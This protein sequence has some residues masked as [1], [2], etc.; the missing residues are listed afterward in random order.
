MIN[1]FCA[2]ASQQSLTDGT[3]ESEQMKE[4]KDLSRKFSQLY[5]SSENSLK[6]IDEM[7]PVSEKLEDSLLCLKVLHKEVEDCLK[8]KDSVTADLDVIKEELEKLKVGFLII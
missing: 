7:I 3:E 1:D 8:R 2:Q 6:E 4:M 5:H